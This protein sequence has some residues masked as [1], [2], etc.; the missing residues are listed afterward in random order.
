MFSDCLTMLGLDNNGSNNSHESSSYE[1][2]NHS[3]DDFSANKPSTGRTMVQSVECCV[4]R[5][6]KEVFEQGHVIDRQ[7]YAQQTQN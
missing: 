3:G 6:L 7:I 1:E 4:C 2:C 5:A